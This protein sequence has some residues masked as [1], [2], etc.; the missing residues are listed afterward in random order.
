ML[1][2]VL[3]TLLKLLHPFMPFITEEIYQ[4]L[5]KCDG[6][7]DILMTAQWPEYTEALSFPAEES[8]MEAV[9]DLIRA[10]RARRAEM[11]VP[12][13]KKASL[14][15]STLEQE[16]FQAGIPFLKRLAYASEVEVGEAFSIPGAVTIVTADAK[17]YIPMDE[18]VDKEA[19]LKR[20]NKELETAQKQLDQVNAKLNNPGFTGKAPA[21]V[22]E[23]A[24]QNAQKLEDKIKM[25]ASSIEALN[26]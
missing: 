1:C 6:A 5:P 2:Y 21:N 4:A 13:S 3:V 17:V 16:V 12:P 24:R 19:E 10:I 20:L 25:I 15:V 8:A 11:N 9:M 23:G 26:G 22:V 18:L 7:E 14:T